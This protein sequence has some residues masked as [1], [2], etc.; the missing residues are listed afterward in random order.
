MK[1]FFICIFLSGAILLAGRSNA[2]GSFDVPVRDTIIVG[3]I[4]TDTAKADTSHFGPVSVITKKKGDKTE[5]T[6]VIIG[7]SDSSHPK[8]V[9]L[10]WFG[11]DLG[12]NNYID[13]SNYGSAEVNDFVPGSPEAS[14]GMFSL[15]TGKS[16]N[17]NIWPILVKVNLINHYVG[18]KTGIGIEMNNYRYAKNITYKNDI[19][20]TYIFRDTINFKKNKLFTEYL[21]IPVLLTFES[22]P[23]HYGRSFHFSGGPTFGYL[24]KS[25][26][27]QKSKAFG[28][29]K[30]NDPFNLEKFRTGLR[31][32][33]GY[34]P[35]TLY[36]AYSFTPIH[37]YGL[38]QYPFSVG[39]CL[40]R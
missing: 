8:N 17:V 15:R 34:G 29:V 20:K 10:D 13:R 2:A 21:T 36:G 32:E 23:Y 39:L 28:K 6:K 38:E 30:N 35:V 27:K 14:S 7:A 9:S 1:G 25:R 12:L 11:F 3:Q 22:N 40:S 33:L 26:T 37:Q 18:F 16:V 31:A 5:T 24:V 4:G 19:S